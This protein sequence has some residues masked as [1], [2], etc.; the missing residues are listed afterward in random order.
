MTI[1][2]ALKSWFSQ[3]NSN[4]RLMRRYAVSGDQGVLTKLYDACGDDLYHFLL[5]LSDSTLA[6]DISQKTWLK[7][8]EKRHLYQDTGLFKAWL[9]TLARNLLIDEYRETKRLV[10]ESAPIDRAAAP[11]ITSCSLLARFDRALNSLAFVQREAFCLQQ[12]GFSMQEIA[13]ITHCG[14]ETVKSRLR[15][16]KASLRE[17]LKEGLGHKHV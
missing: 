6:R 5:T 17:Q 7:V 3:S 9:F 13:Q 4:E 15:Y 12:E 2:L 8:I 1:N 11:A 10:Y 14:Q 16:A